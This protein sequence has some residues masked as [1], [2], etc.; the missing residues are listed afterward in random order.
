MVF[1]LIVICH[2]LWFDWC[3]ILCRTYEQT[4]IRSVKLERVKIDKKKTCFFYHTIK[5]QS[6]IPFIPLC[7]FIRMCKKNNSNTNDFEN[8]IHT[9][10]AAVPTDVWTNSRINYHP[11]PC[12]W[13]SCDEFI[14]SII[15][16]CICWFEHLYA[17]YFFII[18]TI[19]IDILL[20]VRCHVVEFH[21]HIIW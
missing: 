5:N 17:C 4:F 9:V 2:F 12:G 10:I 15:I 14:Y 21:C 18:N 6:A 1:D 11:C 7:L 19:S 8:V 20:C 16:V 13:D 3:E